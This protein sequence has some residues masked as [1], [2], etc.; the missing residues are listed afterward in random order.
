MDI[1]KI[2]NLLQG[3]NIFVSSY[4]KNGKEHYVESTF[5]DGDYTYTTMV[6][7]VYRRAFLELFS[8]DKV[9][10]YLCSIKDYF[11]EDAV[12]K[13]FTTE[14]LNVPNKDGIAYT[15]LRIL[16]GSK[17]RKL[18]SSDFPQNPNAQKIIQGW[19]DKGYVISTIHG[20]KDTNQETPHWMLPLPK[21]KETV[22]EKMS[23][24]FVEK[25]LKTLGR[26]NVYECRQTSGDLPDHK[27]SE[28]RWDDD[29]PEVNSIDITEEEIRNKFQILD[30]QRNQQ[31][32]EVCRHCF[33]TGERGVIYGIRF[34]YEGGPLWNPNVPKTG[35][36]SERGC[37]GCPWYDIQKWREEL[38]KIIDKS[39][40]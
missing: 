3:K 12:N 39:M 18:L 8:E 37:I 23:K 20:S 33:E 38:Q 10:E 34:F 21:L 4:K 16:L 31:K 24:P 29:T 40:K 27:F 7:I 11:K 36:F 30:T 17:G 22:Y 2:N 35:K 19:R 28:V 14:L 26:V 6:P 5:K 25:V 13:W 15:F 9:A 32:R 1:Q